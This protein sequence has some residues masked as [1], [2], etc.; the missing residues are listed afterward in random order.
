MPA[1]IATELLQLSR[2]AWPRLRRRLDGLGDDEYL[3]APAPG[4]WSVRPDAEGVWRP[5]FSVL[6]PDPAP[7]T[8]IAWRLWHITDILAQ[9][10]NATWLGLEPVVADDLTAEPTAAEALIRLE[11]AYGIWEQYLTAVDAAEWWQPIGPVGGRWAAWTRVAFALHELD[12]LIHHGAEVALLRDLYRAQHHADKQDPLV[13]ALLTADHAAV[14]RGRAGRPDALEQIRRHHPELVARAAAGGRWDAVRLLVD[15]GFDPNAAR[16]RTAL[17]DAA[18]ADELAMVRYLIDRGADPNAVDTDFHATPLG[19][20]QYFG[21][22]DV[23]EYLG[24]E[25]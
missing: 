20:A 24:D 22:T 16:G 13:R 5:D 1:D 14:A 17:H 6:P 9:E 18:G 7:M 8:T 12:E 25:R 19:W 21:R 15:L 2:E 23:V 10:R 3:W 4:A 11:R